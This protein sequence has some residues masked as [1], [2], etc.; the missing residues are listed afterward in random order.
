MTQTMAALC[1][2]TNV[3]K[4][5][6]C[7][8]AE[9]MKPTTKQ[10]LMDN[11]YLRGC[12]GT[13]TIASNHLELE[14]Y[15]RAKMGT[16]TFSMEGHAPYAHLEKWLESM[17]SMKST[18]RH[19]CEVGFNAGHSAI[20]WLCAAPAARLTSFDLGTERYTQHA[21]EFVK[22]RFG[23]RFRLIRGNSISTLHPSS[24]RRTLMQNSTRSA[25]KLD[26]C[27]VIV[28]D[29]GHD[30]E[31]AK[32]D[33]LNLNAFAADTHRLIMDDIRCPALHCVGPTFAWD[34]SRQRQLIESDGCT[35]VGPNIGACFGRFKTPRKMMSHE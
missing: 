1:P 22:Q 31:T 3:T 6:Q 29:G 19:I 27:D 33:M 11:L 24:L 9:I 28:I 15:L 34:W 20:A 26:M 2:L 23:A 16:A 30:F 8:H 12:T 32:S 7:V 4:S 17:D 14:S 21:A 10:Y 18:P 5:K 25:Q 13:Q 35:V